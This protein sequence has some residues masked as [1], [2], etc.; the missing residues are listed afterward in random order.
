MSKRA[1]LQKTHDRKE[2]TVIVPMPPGLPVGKATSVA[3]EEFKRVVFK[4]PPVW[5]LGPF[6]SQTLIGLWRTL[7]FSFWYRHIRPRPGSGRG[8]LSPP[9]GS[10]GRFF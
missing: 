2:L 6:L 1:R 4:P 8:G 5:A 9:H 7:R 3:V 10:A